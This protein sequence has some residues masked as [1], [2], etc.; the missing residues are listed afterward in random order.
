MSD[1]S[2]LDVLEVLE[3]TLEA[4]RTYHLQALQSFY[5]VCELG[6]IPNRKITWKEAVQLA[7]TL[8]FPTSY[9]FAFVNQYSRSD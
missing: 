6:Y 4:D 9:V 5:L 3:R 7:Q 8:P 1:I 2:E